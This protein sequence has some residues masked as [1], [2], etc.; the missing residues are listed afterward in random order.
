MSITKI[1]V[2]GVLFLG[3]CGTSV[4]TYQLRP[5]SA[6]PRPPLSVE[7]FMQPPPRPYVTVARLEA[8]DVMSPSSGYMITKLRDRAAELGC[9]A[10]IIDPLGHHEDPHHVRDLSGMCIM[11]ASATASSPP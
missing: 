4:S 10:V 5:I 2:A 8:H 9:D 1:S 6:A 3:A 11:F 7:T